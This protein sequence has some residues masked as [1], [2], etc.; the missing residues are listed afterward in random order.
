MI[1]HTGLDLNCSYSPFKLTAVLYFEPKINLHLFAGSVGG[2]VSDISA[3]S[4]ESV[5]IRGLADT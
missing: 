1:P 2:G 5:E 4:V 3:L